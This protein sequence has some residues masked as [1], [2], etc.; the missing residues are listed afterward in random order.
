[1]RPR[2]LAVATA[3]PGHETPGQTAGTPCPLRAPRAALGRGRPAST[4]LEGPRAPAARIAVLPMLVLPLLLALLAALGASAP[5]AAQGPPVTLTN[6]QGL[7]VKVTTNGI[8]EID[9]GGDLYRFEDV[10]PFF[11]QATTLAGGQ[12]TWRE[13]RSTDLTVAT[14][15][16]VSLSPTRCTLA[17]R[18][19]ALPGITGTCDLVYAY[20]LVAGE[21][22]IAI[23]GTV[24]SSSLSSGLTSVTYRQYLQEDATPYAV[25]GGFTGAMHVTVDKLQASKWNMQ[26]P[27]LATGGVLPLG[28]TNPELFMATRTGETLLIAATHHDNRSQGLLV[29]RDARFDPDNT[30]R[31]VGF[32]GVNAVSTTAPRFGFGCQSYMPGDN[33]PANGGAA[34][35]IGAGIRIDLFARENTAEPY[36]DV[37]RAYRSRYVDPLLVGQ[38]KPA[39]RPAWAGRSVYIAVNVST[40]GIVNEPQTTTFL[41]EFLATYDQVSDVTLLLWGACD[42][43]HFRP[44]PGLEQLTAKVQALA[45]K[46]RK[47]VHMAFYYLP[48]WYASDAT[49][50][51]RLPQVSLDPFANPVRFAFG[52]GA[53]VFFYSVNT[54]SAATQDFYRRWLNEVVAPNGITA[55]FL[56]DAYRHRTFYSYSYGA[57]DEDRLM[58]LAGRTPAMVDGYLWHMRATAD[59]F[60]SR[61]Q[62]SLLLTELGILGRSVPGNLLQGVGGIQ[63]AGPFFIDPKEELQLMPFLND[64]AG[65]H[66]LAGYA[67]TLG[68]EWIELADYADITYYSS[69][70]VRGLVPM[71]TP[72]GMAGR[73]CDFFQMCRHVVDCGKPRFRPLSYC[74]QFAN[75]AIGFRGRHEAILSSWE[76]QPLPGTHNIAKHRM[77]WEATHAV[78]PYYLT[79]DETPFGYFRDPQHPERFALAVANPREQTRNVRFRLSRD[80]YGLQLQGAYALTL[81]IGVGPTLYQVPYSS[82]ASEIDFAFDVPALQMAMVRLEPVN[83]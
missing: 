24:E 45:S 72:I 51:T 18:A 8:Q 2:S 32:F 17:W 23:R 9:A 59:W 71:V 28:A 56:D 4:T 70:V 58:G 78:L 69:Q 19:C 10:P 49:G 63:N 34:L 27:L 61:Q 46:H 77:F 5:L 1:M 31:E 74:S 60:Q 64:V 30:G 29:T 67:G 47:Q 22:S 33:R 13:F 83:N 82:T 44:L 65:H 52:G 73:Y 79:L 6:G 66:Y 76:R 41:D 11:L 50:G 81:Q 25:T 21:R 39:E 57:D 55:L 12:V 40:G 62:P 3:L 37:V 43:E 15:S 38:R 7:T 16:V 36:W 14:K 75:L 54:S 20:E 80:R 26:H 35:A 53:N 42:G 68:N 48:T